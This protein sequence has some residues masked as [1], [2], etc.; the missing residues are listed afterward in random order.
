MN[1]SHFKTLRELSTE[2][3]ITQ[4]E[5]SRRLGLSL[6]SINYIIRAL[7][8]KGYIKTQHFKN[9]NNKLGYI[10]PDTRGNET[11]TKTDEDIYEKKTRGI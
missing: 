6:G 5:L 10:Y 4:R 7:M 8:E 2:G 1:E 3:A 9:S 11:K